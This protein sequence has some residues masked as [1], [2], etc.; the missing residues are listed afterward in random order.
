MDVGAENGCV[1]C[2]EAIQHLGRGMAVPIPSSAGNEG[3][4]WADTR[5]E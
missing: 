2:V 5:E 3:E 1:D 4:F